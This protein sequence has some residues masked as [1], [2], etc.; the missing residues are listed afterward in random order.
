MGSYPKL[1]LNVSYLFSKFGVNRPKQTKVIL[2]TLS[3]RSLHATSRPL[4][5]CSE[6][7]KKASLKLPIALYCNLG[8]N[9]MGFP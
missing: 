2:M 8:H 5:R 9:S 6:N 7:P 1:G 3:V 4:R